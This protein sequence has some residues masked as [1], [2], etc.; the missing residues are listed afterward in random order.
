MTKDARP[1]MPKKVSVTRKASD[2]ICHAKAIAEDVGAI[3]HLMDAC[4]EALSPEVGEVMTTK[5]KELNAALG[6][7]LN[8]I[9]RIHS[10][11]K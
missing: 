1:A 4:P 9:D 8:L 2:E 10:K 3:A 6:V 7:A 11:T 5:M